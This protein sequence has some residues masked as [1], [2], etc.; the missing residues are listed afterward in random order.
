LTSALHPSTDGTYVEQAAPILAEL[1]KRRHSASPVEWA[2]DKLGDVFWSG[3][4]RILEAVRDHRRVAAMTCHGIGKSFS[5]AVIAGWWL[6]SHRPGEAF[7]V[8][9]APTGPQVRIILWKE[10]GRVHKRGELR[11]RVNQTEWVVEVDGKEEVVALGRKPNDYSPTAFQGV[12]APFVLVVVDEAN[13]VRGPLWEAIDSLIANDGSK[14]LAIGNPDDPSGEF[15]DAC[16]PGSGWHVVQIGAFD[17]PNFTGEPLPE[18]ISRQLIGRTYVEEK[19]KKW[20]PH[21]EWTKDGRSVIPARGSASLEDT[22]PFW[23]SKVLGFFPVQSQVGS[24]IPLSW[25]RA[26]QERKLE[27]GEPNELGLDVGAS[28]DGDPSCLGWRRGQ[29][30][31][32]LYEERQ[33]DTMKTAGKLLAHLM[34]PKIGAQVAKVDYIGVGRGVVDALR[35]QGHSVYPVSVSEGSDAVSCVACRHEWSRAQ[36]APERC[37]N[38]GGKAIR[39]EF[40]NLLSELW[41]SVR[42]MFERG[43]IDI[44]AGDEDLASELLSLRWEPNSKGQTVVRYAK[45]QSPNRAD[46]LLMAFAPI[47]APRI[48]DPIVW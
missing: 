2:S 18:P 47:R 6:D 1:T 29:L 39:S 37:P 24:L 46:A 33:P 44:D 7:V 16:K 3:Q 14:I 27:P 31:R 9:T 26:A 34:N 20:A 5:A 38:C 15:F 35:E 41:W 21:W 42:E 12:H 11:G 30:F 23:Q 45:G 40:A 10:I 28:D 4:K 32:V 8:T 22:H 25:I 43:E 17:S 19:R 36:F 13:G 48:D